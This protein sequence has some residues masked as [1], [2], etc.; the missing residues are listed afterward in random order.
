MEG[1]A[2][3]QLGVL[4]DTLCWSVQATCYGVVKV[5]GLGAESIGWQPQATTIARQYAKIPK[6]QVFQPE[7]MNRDFT[8]RFES[9]TQVPAQRM[10]KD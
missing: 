5:R 3:A 6:M 10:L 8:L 4:S 1:L 2:I 9:T 7:L